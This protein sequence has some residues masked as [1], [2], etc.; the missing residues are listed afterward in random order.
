MIRIKQF[1]RKS[2][3]N[4]TI[5]PEDLQDDALLEYIA[6]II[7]KRLT[8]VSPADGLRLL[9]R[10]DNILY[11]LQ[12]QK[13][14]EYNGGIHT[15]HRHTRYHDFFIDHI[16][17]GERVLDIGC[18]NG[19]LTYDIA[20]KAG[21]VVTGIDLNKENIEQ[22]K[23]HRSHKN[24]VYIH[25]DALKVIPHGEFDAVILSNVLEHLPSRSQFLRQLQETIRPRHFLIRVPL[26][27]RDWRVPLKKELGVEWR[28]D[29]T[30]EVEYTVEGFQQ[31]IDTAGLDIISSEVHWG[32]IW[33]EVGCHAK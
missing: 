25:G 31:E 33:A 17:S 5:S 21:G 12:G 11:S 18:G 4:I 32:E 8:K 15:K 16:Q 7:Q 10:I 6:S 29:S 14:S 23:I 24:V 30:H 9:L 26:F 3:V 1:F 22:A 28:L 19:A 2:N 13:S 20:E 27:E